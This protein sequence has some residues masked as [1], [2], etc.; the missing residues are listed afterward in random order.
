MIGMKYDMSG[1][2]T[3]LAL[4][5]IAA[6]LELPLSLVGILPIA[7][8]MPGNA[9]IRPDDVITT[10]SGRTVEILNTDAEGRLILCDALTYCEQFN[11]EYVIDVATLT[12][13]ATVALGRH[14]SALLSNDPELAR[15]LCDAGTISGD[16][17][18]ELPLW[19]EYEE[20]LQSNI[21]DLANVSLSHAGEA[22]TIMGATF[23]A[24]FAKKLHWAHLDIAATATS[25][26]GKER[27][28]TGRPISL[29]TYFL[30]MRCDLVI[31]AQAEIPACKKN[32]R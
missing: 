7:E 25:S 32:E 26:S 4:L 24:H 1:A 22:G 10:L 11:P 18:W 23:L 16:R 13:A 6:Q 17:C 30:L 31:P 19:E 9:A 21:A 14:A 8:N 20:A 3:V 2:A 28:P 5:Q 15:A 27:A 29:L 12:G